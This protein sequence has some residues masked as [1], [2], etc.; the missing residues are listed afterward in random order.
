MK[1]TLEE[2]KDFQAFFKLTIMMR[3]FMNRRV[4]LTALAF[5]LLASCGSNKDAE[6]IAQ[7]YIHKYG[8]D[9]SYEDWKGHEYPGQV[10]TTL[11]NG[12]TVSES[13]EE[14]RLHGPRTVTY[15]HSQ[16]LN[17]LEV[18]SKGE[19]KRRVTYSVRGVPS[20]EELFTSPT[21]TKVTTWYHSGSP[22]SQEDLLQSTKR[23]G[24]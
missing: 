20:M 21:E 7:R 15:P 9:V 13:F 17:Q 1:S 14:G 23:S 3:F 6:V 10:V 2:N 19:L 4:T 11:K 16:T 12:V 5:V 8:Y 24:V 18:Y 22:R